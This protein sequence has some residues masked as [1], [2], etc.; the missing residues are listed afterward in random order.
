MLEGAPGSAC[1]VCAAG[2]F[3]GVG[4]DCEDCPPGTYGPSEALGAC[5]ACAPNSTSP[6]GS[7]H[8]SNCTCDAGFYRP[9]SGVDTC[10]AEGSVHNPG[11]ARCDPCPAGTHFVAESETCA[12]CAAGTTSG[13]GNGTCFPCPADTFSRAGQPACTPCPANASAP[14]GSSS[15]WDCACAAGLAL[16]TDAAG[17]AEC[18]PCGNNTFRAEG[19][20]GCL[21]CPLFALSDPGSMG[22]SNCSCAPGFYGAAGSGGNCTQCPAGRST[23]ARGAASE[24]DCSCPAGEVPSGHSLASGLGAGGGNCVD[25]DECA[26]ALDVGAAPASLVTR[27]CKGNA[28]CTN[29]DGSFTCACTAGFECGLNGPLA[30]SDGNGTFVQADWERVSGGSWAEGAARGASNVS[31]AGAIGGDVSIAVEVLPTR[32]AP[33]T[34]ASA[35]LSGAALSRLQALDPDT[36]TTS[37]AAGRVPGGVLLELADGARRHVLRLSLTEE[38][39]VR[40]EVLPDGDSG[41]GAVAESNGSL[42][43]GAWSHVAVLHRAGGDVELLIDGGAAAQHWPGAPGASCALAAP[44][45]SALRYGAAVV[46][47]PDGRLGACGGNC[48]AAPLLGALR[49]AFVWNASVE[50]EDLSAVAS[51]TSYPQDALAFRGA[52][53]FCVDPDEAAS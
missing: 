21:P 29:S 45:C 4:S 1:V 5:T 51:R 48:S 40:Y 11:E 39:R 46:A 8:W 19:D 3:S 37:G 35:P 50:A 26:A 31:L 32:V 6:G 7:T 43:L 23:A 2:K 9:A 47:R 13:A 53:S 27:G 14:P 18:A 15:L 38:L 34:L 41:C 25:G 16:V 20:A 28:S 36:N 33:L 12:L 30:A 17:A 52:V 22:L 10:C 42:P 49:N 24:A 44:A